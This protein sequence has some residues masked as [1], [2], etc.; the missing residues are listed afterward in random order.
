LLFGFEHA[1]E[2]ESY[3]AFAL[4]GFAYFGARGESAE[5][6]IGCDFVDD[7]DGFG[8]GVAVGGGFG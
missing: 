3:W 7:F 6:R 4:C 8:S 2:Q 1:F 5:F